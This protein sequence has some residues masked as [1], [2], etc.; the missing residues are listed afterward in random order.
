M[1]V[2]YLHNFIFIKTKKT[3]GSAIEMALAPLCGPD[4][5]ITPL[6]RVERGRM[7]LPEGPGLG[8]TVDVKKVAK[9]RV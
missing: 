1:I 4:D 3:A 5:I 6:H 9:Y 2:S 7:P 8:V